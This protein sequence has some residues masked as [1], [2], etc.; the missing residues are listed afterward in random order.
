MPPSVAQMETVT[1]F[2]NLTCNQNC[3]FCTFRRPT[4]PSGFANEARIASEIERAAAAGART[5]VLSGGE[6]TLRPEL[7]RHVRRARELG[8]ERVVLETNA[9]VLA[10][11]GRAEVLK[12]AGLT[13]LRVAMHAADAARADEVSGTHGGLSLTL[14]GMDNARA[15][16][17]ALE[18][19]VAVTR[20][21]LEDL[22]RVASLAVAHGARD[23]LLRVVTDAEPTW[24][25]RY[26]EAARAVV[27]LAEAARELGARVRLDG[28]YGIPLCFF[29]ERRRYPE[30]FATGAPREARGW[31]RIAACEGC[32]ARERCAGV[33]SRYLAI[34]GEAG[35]SAVP[36]RQAR[37]VA[38]LGRDRARAVETEL[39][40]DAFF[41]QEG[42]GVE[43]VVRV[44]FH[45]NQACSF[46]FVDRTLPSVDAARI[47]AEIR[48]AADEGVALL[49]LSGGEPTLHPRLADFVRLARELGLRTQ[50]QTNA[51][52]CD[53]RE[54]VA[55][56]VRA[57]LERAF[58]STHAA[59]AETSDA[60]TAAPGTFV[61][62]LRG[63][64]HLVEAGVDVTLN[65]VITSENVGELPAYARLVAERWGPRVTVNLSLAHAST[66]LVPRDELTIPRFAD[67]RRSVDEALAILRQAGVRWC[68]FDGQCGIPLCLLGDGWLDVAALAPLASPEPP[69]GF[70]KI[71]ACVRC[72]L[73]DRCVGIRETYAQ[74]YGTSEIDGARGRRRLAVLS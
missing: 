9:M 51:V 39:V 7:A 42:G 20:P 14:R 37:F 69:A 24:V 55:A 30:L 70:L 60:L 17:L 47:E 50:I 72:E 6:P 29:P 40:N 48:R 21:L 35:A 66:D 45:C 71:E 25:P 63:I 28:R 33:P 10:Y 23:L 4:D 59:R 36:Q 54:Y 67:V 61:R 43:R 62:T 44:N 12:A 3:G 56:L 18:V 58:V 38:G 31:T 13:R 2:T 64:D 49:S 41:A 16:G 22:P 11:P 53:D 27:A 15:A 8:I 5:L 19:S 26:D 68:G 1:V 32:A 74:L 52:R 46:C 65:Y 73:T 34:H 57:G